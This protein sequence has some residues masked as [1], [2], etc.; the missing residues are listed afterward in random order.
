MKTPILA[1][2]LLLSSPAFASPESD[3]I[4]ALEAR[5]AAL[6]SALPKAQ[7]TPAPRPSRAAVLAAGQVASW[8]HPFFAAVGAPIFGYGG[9]HGG[10][11]ASGGFSGGTVPLATTFTDDVTFSGG[12]AAV[13]FSAASSTTVLTTSH[14]WTDGT[15]TLGSITDLGTSGRFAA[16]FF[17]G[18]GT[19]VAINEDTIMLQNDAGNTTRLQVNSSSVTVGVLPL[20]LSPS[21][22]TIAD[23]GDGSAATRTA[24]PTSSISEVTCNDADGCVWT[25]TETSALD[26][27]IYYI[28]NTSA[29]NALTMD[30]VAGQVLLNGGADVVLGANDTLAVYYSTDE[31][32]WVQLGA[33]GNN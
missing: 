24:L 12:T 3:R 2:L 22:V 30:H 29:A 21:A 15:N 4:A 16:A 32:A 27:G 33:A 7:P 5:L 8:R 13:T 17:G 18:T 9:V 31:S 25:I 20:V 11:G 26:G 28:R 14:L 23:S 6:E 19:T 10:G 1:A